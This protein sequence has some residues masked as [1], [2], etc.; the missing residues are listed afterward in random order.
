MIKLEIENKDFNDGEIETIKECIIENIKLKL[1]DTHNTVVYTGNKKQYNNINA[2][3]FLNV[4]KSENIIKLQNIIQILK[5]YMEEK[6]LI[7][8]QI[9]ISLAIYYYK[10]KDIYQSICNV[11]YKIP[12]DVIKIIWDY[13]FEF[14]IEVK[15]V[16]YLRDYIKNRRN[17]NVTREAEKYINVYNIGLI[18]RVEF[19][20]ELISATMEKGKD[21]PV[22]TD[23]FRRK[24][25]NVCI[26]LI[27]NSN[28]SR[29]LG[30]VKQITTFMSFNYMWITSEN[31]KLIIKILL[32]EVDNIKEKK[33]KNISILN[34]QN[35]ENYGDIEKSIRN[36]FSWNRR[37]EYCKIDKI[38][39]SRGKNV[40]MIIT[41]DESLVYTEAVSF[42]KIEMIPILI[43]DLKRL[44]MFYTSTIE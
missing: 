41:K 8:K 31:L 26:F 20:T 10:N 38:I 22:A 35:F 40:I 3:I 44:L 43:I 36:I 24:Y 18:E 27:F 34:F 37:R 39:R 5:Q 17:D 9:D 23:E 14:I 11:C 1:V 33:I 7:Y 15:L 2:L 12:I 25:N 16:Y 13:F 19:K 32:D 6:K 30:D 21:L 42:I 29:I 28:G 4:I